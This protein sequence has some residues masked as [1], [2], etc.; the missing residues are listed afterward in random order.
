MLYRVAA[1]TGL[2]ASELSSL[3]PANFRIDRS[4]SA[5]VVRVAYSKQRRDDLQ[6]IRSDLAALLR[7]WTLPGTPI[8]SSR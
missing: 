2:R 6:P 8:R 1:G 5:I 7:L 4:T 3:T